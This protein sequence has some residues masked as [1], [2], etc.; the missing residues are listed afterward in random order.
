MLIRLPILS[1]YFLEFPLLPVILI[2]SVGADAKALAV[3]MD[4]CCLPRVGKVGTFGHQYAFARA[5]L[6]WKQEVSQ[7]AKDT[8][9]IYFPIVCLFLSTA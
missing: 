1:T 2:I 4:Y 7:A 5:P 3:L 9:L 8:F 6:W